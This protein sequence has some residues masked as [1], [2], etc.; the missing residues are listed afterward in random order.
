MR[1]DLIRLLKNLVA[2]GVIAIIGFFIYQYFFNSENDELKIEDTPIHIESIKTIAEISTVSYKDEVVIDTVELYKKQNS[3]YDPREWMRY[4]D[5]NIKRRL[6]LIVK[7]E[8][9]IG[10]NLTNGNYSVNSNADTIWLHLPE[11]KILDVLVAPSKTEIFQ[12]KGTW[13]DSDRKQ[14]EMKAK[15]KLKNNAIKLRLIEK[16]RKSVV[17]LFSSLIQSEKKLIIDFSY[18]K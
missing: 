15:L 3:I 12:E 6:T 4:Y 9:K 5:R 1:R 18:E 11:P 17:Y 14:L 2:L 13:K 16:S 10:V 8:V 7:G